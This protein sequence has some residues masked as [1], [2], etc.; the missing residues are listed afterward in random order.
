MEYIIEPLEVG[1]EL[2]MDLD[3]IG[4]QIYYNGHCPN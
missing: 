2:D 1:E 4:D 3:T